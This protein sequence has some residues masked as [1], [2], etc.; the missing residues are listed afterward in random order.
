MGGEGLDPKSSLPACRVLSPLQAEHWAPA[1][2]GAIHDTAKG[3]RLL[4]AQSASR[5]RVP[6][7]TQARLIPG[8]RFEET[9]RDFHTRPRKVAWAHTFS[10]RGKIKGKDLF[11][12]FFSSLQLKL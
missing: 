4:G 9:A 6:Q 1:K 2:T 8:K 12:F 7:R 3:V 10:S 11:S 5:F